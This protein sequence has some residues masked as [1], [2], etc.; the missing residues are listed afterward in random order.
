M[1]KKTKFVAWLVILAMVITMLPATVFAADIEADDPDAVSIVEDVVEE[2][3]VA[4]ETKEVQPTT[5]EAVYGEEAA[6]DDTIIIIPSEN[7]T[8]R[9]RMFKVE[10]ASAVENTD[11]TVLLTIQMSAAGYH[12]FFKGTKDEAIANGDKPETWIA[13][14][15]NAEGK[16]VFQLP[17]TADE[18]DKYVSFVSISN[19]KY[20]EYKEG[21]GSFA[22]ALYGRRIRLNLDEKTLLTDDWLDPAPAQHVDELIAKIQSQKFTSTTW[23]DC[24]AAKAAWDALSED[25]KELV[26]EADYFG[27]DTGDA[28]KDDPL[29]ADG[30]GENEILVVSFGTSFN[31]NRAATIGAIEKAIA[32]AY[33]N[34]SVRRAFTA[35]IIINHIYARDGIKIDNVEQALDRAVANGVKK[36]IV[37]PTHLMHGEEYDELQEALAPYKDQIVIVVTE[38]L[39]G[40]VGETAADVNTDKIEVAKAV[41][42]A[43]CADAG[44]KD[45]AAAEADGAAIVLMGHGTAHPANI[46]YEQMQTVMNKLGYG[47][48]FIGTVEGL[49]ESTECEAVIARV[50]AAGYK[51][52]FLRPLMVVAGDHA[53][54]D[55]AD[56]DDDES[57]YSMFTATGNFDSVECQIK[58][59]GELKDVQDLYVYHVNEEAPMAQTIK[60]TAKASSTDYATLAKKAQT[61]DAITVKG[62]KTTLSYA[63]A[64]GDKEISVNA[65]NGKITIAKG[66]NAGTYTAKIKVTAAA[67]EKYEAAETTVTVK[68]TVKQSKQPMVV[69]ATKKTQAVKY[70]KTKKQTIKNAVKVTKNQGTLTYKISNTKYFS[71]SKKGVITVKAG[72]PKNSYKVTVTVT[73]KGNKNYK[74]GSGKATFTI[75]V[76]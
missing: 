7:I 63:F 19:T 14:T 48:V 39:L 38:P 60:A 73:A 66:T 65:K 51:K 59:L 36:M 61:F 4:P 71:I 1:M 30:I 72:T 17:L 74:K 35:Q 70:N 52:V 9:N 25:E 13:G 64:S 8:N 21:K 15:P 76:K 22:A 57:W 42:A 69:K 41:V 47:N 43:A 37:Q 62:A 18:I 54:N 46:T 27:L 34:W 5:E 29:N 50:A 12:Y 24:E 75:K 55:M 23:A 49:P 67:T 20:E 16:Y 33:P 3:V 58:G 53:N 11:G 10:T 68:V 2:Q 26:E 44:Y 56:P 6:V 40:E 31:D 45:A 28:S 32:K